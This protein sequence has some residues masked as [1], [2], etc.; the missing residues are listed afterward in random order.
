MAL[1]RARSAG[2][3]PAPGQTEILFQNAFART[4]LEGASE[5][6]L[7]LGA[8][9]SGGIPEVRHHP[10]PE[11]SSPVDKKA[12]SVLRA[13][14]GVRANFA[15]STAPN[16]EALRTLTSANTNTRYSLEDASFNSDENSRV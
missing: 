1:P 7:L 4:R 5:Q 3:A 11:R 10:L 15:T 14:F 9:N 2:L 6:N 13:A 8:L 12:Q 16:F